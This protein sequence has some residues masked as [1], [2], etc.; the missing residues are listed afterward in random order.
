MKCSGCG[1]AL[2][3]GW[4]YPC[5]AKETNSRLLQ[6]QKAA[7]QGPVVEVALPPALP[8]DEADGPPIGFVVQGLL[9]PDDSSDGSSRASSPPSDPISIAASVSM[10]SLLQDLRAVRARFERIPRGAAGTWDRREGPSRAGD[11]GG[12]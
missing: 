3:A 9:P 11:G 12:T 2:K 7:R 8:S 10:P 6:A 4:C 5:W 1:K